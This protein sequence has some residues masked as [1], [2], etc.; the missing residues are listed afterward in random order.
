MVAPLVYFFL[1]Q[2]RKPRM[3]SSTTTFTMTAKPNLAILR[4]ILSLPAVTPTHAIKKE[5]PIVNS[6]QSNS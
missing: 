2:T 6:C 4:S 3:S 1:R 5:L